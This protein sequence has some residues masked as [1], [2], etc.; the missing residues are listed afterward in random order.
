[1]PQNR[2]RNPIA[3]TT[4]REIRSW[5]YG[6]MLPTQPAIKCLHKQ[7]YLKVIN[8]YSSLNIKHLKKEQNRFTGHIG[9]K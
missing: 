1:M 9:L 5:G 8:L 7:F 2:R 6:I 3:E 4:K